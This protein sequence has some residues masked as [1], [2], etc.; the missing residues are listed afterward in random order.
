ME[1]EEPAKRKKRGN[2]RNNVP[3][4]LQSRNR[5]YQNRCY[6][7]RKIELYANIAKLEELKPVYQQNEAS[8][9]EKKQ[10]LL[11]TLGRDPLSV[12]VNHVLG[13]TRNDENYKIQLAA[14]E[15]A[16]TN[17]HLAGQDYL[18]NP[19]NKFAK[20][21]SK[22]KYE[23]ETV[24]TRVEVMEKEFKI[25]RQEQVLQLYDGYL[26]SFYYQD[27]NVPNGQHDPG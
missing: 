7:K 10:F 6:A 12:Q 5:V 18:N 3:T 4:E 15:Q 25:V 11:G 23:M 19:I 26:Q 2:R 9:N 8:I 21:K 1:V 16:E 13:Q 14:K 24:Q 20:A 22:K 27:P 17:F